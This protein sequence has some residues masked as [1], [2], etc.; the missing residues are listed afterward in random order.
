MNSTDE[1]CQCTTPCAHHLNTVAKRTSAQEPQ[2]NASL[3]AYTAHSF[4]W[5][6]SHV[7]QPHVSFLLRH[8][9]QLAKPGQ[10]AALCPECTQLRKVG[11]RLGRQ[12]WLL[13][14]LSVRQRGLLLTWDEGG[15]PH[16]AAVAVPEPAHRRG[17]WVRGAAE[18]MVW[19]GL[20]SER[21]GWAPHH[22]GDRKS[23]SEC[24]LIGRSVCFCFS[25]EH[26]G[27]GRYPHLY[28]VRQTDI[29]WD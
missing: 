15:A 9:Q 17:R 27:W 21:W 14:A 22:H 10:P 8:P 18:A 5:Q 13:P 26:K 11:T 1:Q 19:L 24:T 25:L 3:Y 16:R 2:N 20:C 6:H 28:S 29:H 23:V 4:N 7:T 12:R